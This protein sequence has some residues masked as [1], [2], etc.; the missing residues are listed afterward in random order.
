MVRDMEE[1]SRQARTEVAQSLASEKRLQ[2]RVTD[3]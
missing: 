1:S 3:L 2:K